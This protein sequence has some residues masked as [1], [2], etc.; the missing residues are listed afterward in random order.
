MVLDSLDVFAV[1]GTELARLYD[2]S[3]V[4][5]TPAVTAS[6]PNVVARAYGATSR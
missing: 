1:D 4:T 5:A 6:H 3:L 2:A